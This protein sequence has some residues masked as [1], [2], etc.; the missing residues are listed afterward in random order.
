M[1]IVTDSTTVEDEYEIAN[2]FNKYFTSFCNIT[3]SVANKNTFT[4]QQNDRTMFMD[5]VTPNLVYN[6]I[7]D[8]QLTNSVGT[9]GIN[10][11]SLCSY[12]KIYISQSL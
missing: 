1:K 6:T 8:L 7:N 9:D 2:T 10:I 5:S 4:L 12:S 11:K 3:T